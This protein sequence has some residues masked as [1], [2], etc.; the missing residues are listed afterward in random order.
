MMAISRRRL[1]YLIATIGG[2]V[3]AMSL[4]RWPWSNRGGVPRTHSN[5]Y[6]EG[7]RSLVGV[8]LGSG[9]QEDVPRMVRL[10]VDLIGGINR[11]EW[12]GR[13]VFVKPNCN[14]ND[15][16]PRTTNPM[17]VKTVVEMLFEAGASEVKVGDSSNINYDTEDVM[18]DQGIWEA[19]EEAGGEV[20]L[21]DREEWVHMEIPNARWFKEAFIAKPILEAERLVEL[22]V[23]KS[24]D[25]AGFSMSMKLFVGAVHRDNR[26]DPRWIPS[27]KVLHSCGNI[28]EGIAELNQL[29]KPDLIVMDG[30]RSI[31]AGDPI[32]GVVRDTNLI[33]TSGDRIVNDIVGLS[34]IKMYGLWPEVVEKDVWEQGQIRRGLELELGRGNGE[35]KIVGAS[36]VGEDRLE[37]ILQAVHRISGIPYVKAQV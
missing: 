9:R 30:T 21:F 19:V 13:S 34:V 7:G 35:A 36:L 4:L 27:P 26:V 29:F 18:R 5:A 28:Q 6:S 14:S 32:N 20:V 15:P 16:Y 24:H 23:I 11:V 17:V 22:P 37:Y 10:G 2:G 1:L 3:F 33:V 12:K 8:V 31:V 25:A